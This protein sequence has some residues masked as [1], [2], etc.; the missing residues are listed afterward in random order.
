M[1]A[2]Q[3][4]YFSDYTYI[5]TKHWRYLALSI[6]IIILWFVLTVCEENGHG[7]I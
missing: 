6:R 3:A 1:R 2:R 7:K 5:Q 4:N